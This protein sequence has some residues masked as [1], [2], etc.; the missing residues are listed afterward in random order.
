[1]NNRIIWVRQKGVLTYFRRLPYRLC[2]LLHIWLAVT[3]I[4]F[5]SSITN[6]QPAVLNRLAYNKTG[7]GTA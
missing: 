4:Q 3:A 5:N 2:N 7:T 6:E 1:M